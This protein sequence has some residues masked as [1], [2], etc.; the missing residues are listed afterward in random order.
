MPVLRRDSV[1][2]GHPNVDNRK[3]TVFQPPDCITHANTEWSAALQKFDLGAE[4]MAG[5]MAG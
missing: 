4:V 1:S 2:D 3:L 5:E